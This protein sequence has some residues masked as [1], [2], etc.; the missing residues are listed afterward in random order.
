MPITRCDNGKWKIGTGRC[1]Y[2]TKED[3]VRAQQAMFAQ[4]SAKT[5][6]SVAKDL[7]DMVDPVVVEPYKDGVLDFTGLVS[8]EFLNKLEKVDI[9]KPFPNEHAARILPPGDFQQDSFRSKKIATGIRIIVGRLKGKT[10]TTAQ[11]YRLHVDH[12]SAS[13]AKAWL[14]DHDVKYIRF[15]PATGKK[16]NELDVKKSISISKVDAER[17]LVYGV[18]YEPEIVDAQGDFANAEEIE[19]ACHLFMQ[20]YQNVGVMHEEVLPDSSASVVENYITSQNI[21][22]GDDRVRKGSWVMVVKVHDDELWESVKKG[23]LT[24]FSMAGYSM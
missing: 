8:D 14:K 4:R 11:A 1:Q 7:F 15:E 3:A 22:L 19:K 17:R 6:V 24:G 13:E 23:E 2:E 18:V 20:D 12:F 10:T 21:M 5:L 9:S 16:K